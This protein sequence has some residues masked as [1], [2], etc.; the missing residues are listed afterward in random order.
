MADHFY[1]CREFEISKFDIARLTC[2]SIQSLNIFS[3]QMD[4][5]KEITFKPLLKC[6]GL[7]TYESWLYQ[8]DAHMCMVWSLPM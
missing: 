5:G 6:P 8:I 1:I 7:S 3:L 4:I 2:I